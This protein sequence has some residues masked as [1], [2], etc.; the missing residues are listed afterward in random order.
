MLFGLASTGLGLI[1]LLR[2]EFT[3]V[4][5]PVPDV[6]R[7]QVWL[8]YAGASLFT[9]AGIALQRRQSVPAAATILFALYLLF[10]LSWL[11]R[12]AA[13]PSL[14][15]TW[16]GFCEQ[17]ALA[18]GA[19]AAMLIAGKKAPGAVAACRIAFGLCELVFGLAHFLSLAETV[20]MTPAWLPPGPGFWAMAT[21]ALH[22][23]AGV[24]LIVGFRAEAAARLLAAMF[25]S[26]G[27][28]VWAPRVFADPSAAI[29]WS[30][31]AINLAMAG[32]VWALADLLASHRPAPVHARAG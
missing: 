3:M 6:V 24:A 23:G 19:V 13:F 30:G 17:L 27:A 18:L 8:A 21:G 7:S 9:L 29:G 16:L 14:I 20:S 4:W 28:F 10:A 22:F 26:F 15:G 12:V 2:G 31:S 11:R 5:H 32:A 1:G 25:L